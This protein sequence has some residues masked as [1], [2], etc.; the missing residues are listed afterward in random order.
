MGQLSTG[1]TLYLLNS[2][3]F[4]VVWSLIYCDGNCRES[5]S[6]DLL[7]GINRKHFHNQRHQR[8]TTV[9]PQSPSPQL[10]FI[11]REFRKIRRKN[12]VQQLQHLG[13]DRLYCI[14]FRS[15]V[16]SLVFWSPTFITLYGLLY[17]YQ[18]KM[19]DGYCWWEIVISEKLNTLYITSGNGTSG[20]LITIT[21]SILHMSNT[22]IL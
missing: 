13:T 12:G 22:I 1:I 4:A 20:I 8:Y 7:T 15:S 11:F 6:S 3:L 9:T 19:F 21:V 10:T 5:S 17:Y 14:T 18:E 16:V 2:P